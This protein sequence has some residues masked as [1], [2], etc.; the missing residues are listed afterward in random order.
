MRPAGRRKP[1]P[2]RLAPGRGP[3]RARDR[4]GA[5]A[6][7][8]SRS[9]WPGLSPRCYQAAVTAYLA[10]P[11]RPDV[12]AAQVPP[13]AARR[14]LFLVGLAE[15]WAQAQ[16]VAARY[17]GPL[18]VGSCDGGPAESYADILGDV[19]DQARRYHAQLV[20]AGPPWT[21]TARECLRRAAWAEAQLAR[22]EPGVC[23]VEVPER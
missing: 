2:P 20:D 23:E 21:T 12:L 8:G 17:D 6:G 3:R 10:G 16:Y 7:V 22:A 1:Q 9:P 19:R 11:H 14:F 13:E 15:L 18:S 5:A 4:S